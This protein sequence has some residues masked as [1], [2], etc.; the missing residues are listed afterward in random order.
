VS[1]LWTHPLPSGILIPVRLV[2]LCQ[3]KMLA[4]DHV[5]KYNVMC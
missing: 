1:Y 4:S 5:G 2:L 3:I